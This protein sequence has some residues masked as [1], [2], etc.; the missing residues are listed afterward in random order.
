[1][2]I[3]NIQSDLKNSSLKNT[4][5]KPNFKAVS[6]TV[7]KRVQTAANNPASKDVFVKLAG[8]T[9][10]TAL[11]TWVK[12]LSNAEKTDA[13][14]K[15]DIIDSNWSQKS[16]ELFLD[17]DK[18]GQFINLVSKADSAE[19]VIW[20]KGLMSKDSVQIENKEFSPEEIEMF[21]EPES[22]ETFMS[23]SANNTLNSIVNQMKALALASD[24]A[25][26]KALN[27]IEA[28][29]NALVKQADVLQNSEESAEIYAKLANIMKTFAIINSFG[30]PK[31][32]DVKNVVEKPQVLTE[33]V[34][35]EETVP[36]PETQVEQPKKEK[37]PGGLTL[38]GK[39]DV[40]SLDPKGAK[41]RRGAWAASEE[42][43]NS[44][45]SITDVAEPVKKVEPIKI[46]DSNKAFIT[47]VFLPIFKDQAAIN[48]E[49]YGSHIDLI[50]KIY[51]KYSNEA[52]KSSFL[53]LLKFSDKTKLLETYSKI[54]NVDE[55]KI[56]F[57]NFAKIEQ[58]KND[59]GASLT[60]EEYDKLNSYYGSKIKYA[61]IIIDSPERYEKQQGKK[62]SIKI[63]YLD[64]I[65]VR[66]RLAIV[67]DFHKII[68]NAST[69]NSIVGE[70]VE[71][72]KMEDIKKEILRKLSAY[73]RQEEHGSSKKHHQSADYENILSFL[74]ININDLRDEYNRGELDIALEDHLSENQYTNELIELLNNENFKDFIV[75]THARMRFI[76]RFVFEQG[77]WKGKTSKSQK[78]Q[79]TRAINALE[80]SLSKTPY[81]QFTNYCT[82]KSSPSSSAKYGARVNFINDTVIGLDEK[83]FIHTIF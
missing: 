3:Y 38:L 2:K 66:E 35:G 5:V 14:S 48:P 36:E 1:M 29:L 58:L 83:G 25:R 64:G 75:T 9:G 69:E 28:K 54:A 78:A 24:E 45:N 68:F 53:N 82:E 81:L 55:D 23:V 34:V 10:L 31:Q 17:P 16:S 47:E 6:P 73:F 22:N 27:S 21:L 77:K 41:K 62:A 71:E 33:E 7:M 4:G 13:I 67:S 72:V 11:V 63:N 50:Q 61:E 30:A 49:I 43:N 57:V 20:T 51:E 12:S 70:P 42:K 76:D 65:P 32:A 80:N 52:V 79:T 56:Q 15:L 74:R 39:I 44:V 8:L 37:T 18:Q 40:E 26:A 19:S 59:F 46:T 60:Q